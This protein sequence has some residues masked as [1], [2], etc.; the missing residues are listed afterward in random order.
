MY[1][2]GAVF[3]QGHI[4]TSASAVRLLRCTPVNNSFYSCSTWVFVFSSRLQ[5]WGG[6]AGSDFLRGGGG[7]G[8]W[9]CPGTDDD[10]CE[11]EVISLKLWLCS[12]IFSGNGNI[13][14]FTQKMSRW[15]IKQT[16][17]SQIEYHIYMYT[18]VYSQSQ[19]Y[20]VVIIMS[21]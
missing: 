3:H 1:L 19:P 10:T 15:R 2:L 13:P 11:A 18:L 12:L 7:G 20:N 4:R 16:R 6:G 21:F 8:L 5:K 9:V 14:L 17:F